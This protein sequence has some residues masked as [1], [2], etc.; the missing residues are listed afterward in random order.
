MVEKYQRDLSET[1]AALYEEGQSRNKLQMELDAKD[2]EIELLQQK[3]S[4]TNLDTASIHSGSLEDDVSLHNS[5]INSTGKRSLHISSINS[6][7]K[8]I[9]N[10][11]TTLV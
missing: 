6:T 10:P 5:S 7:D 4:T 1:Q 2:S 3:L 9:N 8:Q 11:C